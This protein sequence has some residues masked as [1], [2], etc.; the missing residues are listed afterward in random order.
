MSSF[1]R[2]FGKQTVQTRGSLGSVTN[3]ESFEYNYAMCSVLNAWYSVSF[4]CVPD[5][6]YV[7][8]VKESRDFSFLCTGSGINCIGADA[9][10][11]VRHCRCAGHALLPSVETSGES[12]VR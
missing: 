2:G 8:G 1:V 11:G 6:L 4:L 9:N 10:I 5:N 12:H 7:G 3:I